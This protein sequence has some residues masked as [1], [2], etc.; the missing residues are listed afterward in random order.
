MGGKETTPIQPAKKTKPSKTIAQEKVNKKEDIEKIVYVDKNNSNENVIYKLNDFDESKRQVIYKKE[1]LIIYRCIKAD[2]EEIFIYYIDLINIEKAQSNKLMAYIKLMASLN[3]NNHSLKII[4][5]YIQK[6]S[7]LYIITESYKGDL[8]K[9]LSFHNDK[10]SVK[11]IKDIFLQINA[12][13]LNIYMNNKNILFENINLNNIVYKNDNNFLLYF[14][15]IEEFMLGGVNKPISPEYLLNLENIQINKTYI[16]NIGLILYRLYEG[17]EFDYQN[18]I[19]ILYKLK[20]ELSN[21]Y[22]S[23]SKDEKLLQNLIQECLT[24]ENEKRITLEKFFLHPFFDHIFI[25]KIEDKNQKSEI[26]EYLN[27]TVINL[28]KIFFKNLNLACYQD[29]DTYFEDV[30]N[31][32]NKLKNLTKNEENQIIVYRIIDLQKEENNIKD[33]LKNVNSIKGELLD[34]SLP[35]LLFLFEDKDNTRIK[36]VINNIIK[37][38]NLVK[39]DK[40]FIFYSKYSNEESDLNLLKKKIYRAF[41]YFNEYGDIYIL[42]DIKIDLREIKFDHY[43]NIICIA[44]SQMGKSTFINKYMNSFENK[45]EEIKAKEGGNEKTCSR[46]IAKYYINNSPITLI[47]IIGY[48]GEKDT[49]DKLKHIVDEMSILILKNE[50]HLILYIIEFNSPTLFF[51]QEVE[52]FETLNSNVMKPKLL[53]IRTKSPINPYKVI[54][55]E[56]KLALDE[57]MDKQKTLLKKKIY[58]MN[59]NFKTIK[60]NNEG[61]WTKVINFLFSWVSEEKD[62]FD[63]DNVIFVNLTDLENPLGGEDIAPFGMDYVKFKILKVFEKILEEENERKKHWTKLSDDFTN[64][65]IDISQVLKYINFYNIS[66]AYLDEESNNTIKSLINKNFD[67]KLKIDMVSFPPLIRLE[68]CP[69]CGKIHPIFSF[70][71]LLD[72]IFDYGLFKDENNHYNLIVNERFTFQ[73]LEDF[74]S[75]KIKCISSLE[76]LLEKNNKKINDDDNNKKKKKKDEDNIINDKNDEK[77]L[78]INQ[79][80]DQQ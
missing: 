64:N 41:S 10:L 47:D 74:I 45:E 15:P 79:K 8:K 28:S 25:G 13:L 1:K 18:N 59:E 60:N 58:L 9:Y 2:N 24:I 54:N 32:N 68:L 72:P 46:K 38:E 71:S 73:V 56:I 14:Y 37:N 29:T 62:I 65:R 19:E 50:I 51:S 26:R 35:F 27:I 23:S 12:I 30:N 33:I 4:E 69:R 52:I 17:K 53:F 70:F 40:R 75:Y 61:K 22:N 7:N 5:C 39:L 42:N 76:Y 34:K 80:N 31:F 57:L 67:K 55:N 20:E 6:K 36:N 16:W 63:Y 77:I 44:R 66:T 43:I 21:K 11:Q 3:E 78:L 48:D 49:I